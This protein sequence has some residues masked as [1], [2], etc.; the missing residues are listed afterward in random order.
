MI[1]DTP[2]KLNLYSI[3]YDSV[4]RAEYKEYDNSHIK[5]IEQG[6]YLFE[7][8]PMRELAP[9]FN[10]RDYYGIFSWKFRFKTGLNSLSLPYFLN[11]NNFEKYDII[12]MCYQIGQPYLEF[13]ENQHKGFMDLFTKVCN[14]LNIEVKEPTNVVYANQFI[15]KGKIYKEFL[16]VVNSAIDL[17]EMDYLEDAFQDS[18]YKGLPPKEL[19]EKTGLEYYTFHTFILE[20]LFSVWIED[21]NFKILNLLK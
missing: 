8:N 2:P 1:H 15:T 20:R 3:I 19:K 10:D 18:G 9:T 12:T 11:K 4:Q 7:Y 5:T 14:R 17:L 21:K 16:K 13:T 6:S